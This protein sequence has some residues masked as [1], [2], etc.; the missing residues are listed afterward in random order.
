LQLPIRLVE[1]LKSG[2]VTLI[3][4]NIPQIEVKAQDRRIDINATDKQFIKDLIIGAL[5]ADNK[6]GKSAIAVI[7]EM[8]P[9]IRGIAEDLCKEGV[10][11]TISYK[12]DRLATI[13]SDADS[14]FS[15]LITGTKGIEI[16]SPEK[17]ADLVI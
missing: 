9:M 4:N 2:K 11:I 7:I 1:A 15:R 6:G 13:G 16:N 17:L 3:Q 14:K 8:L 10:T 5:E 12:G